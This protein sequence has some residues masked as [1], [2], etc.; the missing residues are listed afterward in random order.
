MRGGSH[1]AMLPKLT[2]GCKAAKRSA[3]WCSRAF[4]TSTERSLLL[5]KGIL[6]MRHFPQALCLTLFLFPLSAAGTPAITEFMADNVSDLIDGASRHSDWIE[7]HN[8]A[9]SAQDMA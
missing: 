3:K 8:P 2:H 5:S 6:P 9:G 1:S 4:E 7:V